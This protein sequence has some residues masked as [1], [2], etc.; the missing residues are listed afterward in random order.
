M[1]IQDEIAVSSV[2]DNNMRE[3]LNISKERQISEDM[4]R[5][6]ESK[7]KIMSM[8]NSIDYEYDIHDEF[9]M[10]KELCDLLDDYEDV[11]NNGVGISN[12]ESQKFT[13]EVDPTV[14][15]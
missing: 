11:L 7:A 3:C 13:I 5:A 8:V 1:M 15:P 4:M 6:R 10:K 12:S 2:I 14:L 9:P